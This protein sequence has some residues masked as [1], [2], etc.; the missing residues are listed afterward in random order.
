MHAWSPEQRR[1][2]VHNT[3]QEHAT[4]RLTEQYYPGWT[5]TIDGN[6]A[7]IERCQ[8]A[9]QCLQIPPGSPIVEFRYWP[10]SLGAGAAASLASIGVLVVLLRRRGISKSL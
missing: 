3:R 10:R 4:F 8:Q 6:P 7:R 9:F 5:A 1:F 2:Q